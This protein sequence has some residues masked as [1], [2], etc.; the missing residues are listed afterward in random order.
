MLAG[1]PRGDVNGGKTDEEERG[2]RKSERDGASN[3]WAGRV[4]KL[5]SISQLIQRLFSGSHT[6]LVH[7]ECR[8]PFQAA[9]FLLFITRP[10]FCLFE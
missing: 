5:W 1:R 7:L 10:Y 2:K 8:F 6:R 4:S 9:S 3:I